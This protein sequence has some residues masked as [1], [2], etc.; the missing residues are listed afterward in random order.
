MAGVAKSEE[1]QEAGYEALMAAG[2]TTESDDERSPGPALPPRRAQRW[3][4]ATGEWHEAKR[5]R[6]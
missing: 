2:L 5:R 1:A 6:R 3:A 4:G